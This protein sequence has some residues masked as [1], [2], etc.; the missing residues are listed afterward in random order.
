FF[1]GIMFFNERFNEIGY[2]RMKLPKYITARKGSLHYQRQYPTKLRHL[3]HTK[4]FTQPLGLSA[5]NVTNNEITKA[6][7]EAD[8]AFERQLKLIASSDPDALSATD[9]DKAVI[10]FLR[11]RGLNKGAYVRVA[12]DSAI[13]AQEEAEQR[14][15]QPDEGNHADWAIPEMEDVLEKQDRGEKLSLKDTIIGDAYMSLI[16]KQKAKPKSLG[17]LWAEYVSDRSIDVNSRVGKKYVNYWEQWIAIAGDA[18]IGPLSQAHIREGLAAYAKDRAGKVSSSSIERELSPVMACLRLGSEVYGFD[19]NLKLPRIKKTAPNSR[20]PLE[21]HHQL[22]LIKAV[23][24]EDGIKPMYGVAILLCLQGGMMVSEISRLRPEDIA[25]DAVVP[26]LKIVNET[27]NDDRKRIVP[28]ILGLE[29]IKAHLSETIKWLAG[30]TESTPSATL[31]K[32]MR[33]TID[34]PSTS[35]HCLRHTLKVNAQN[36]GVSVLTLASIAGWADPQ[37]KVSKHLLNY[38]STGVSQ[39]A[40]IIKLRDDSIIIHNELI[41][42]EDSLKADS[43]VLAFG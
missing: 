30:S 43:N 21:P 5:N 38:G 18:L 40:M 6:A 9:K 33:R 31:K 32:I 8:E 27:K 11:K 24:T 10:E 26:H 29:L 37:R 14:Q 35:V 22:E 15:M 1:N 42:L 16:N 4:V 12:K 28:I 13:A 19:W 39:S 34:S 41:Q 25:L 20:H 2:M 7:L 36:A 3:C 23:L 17:S